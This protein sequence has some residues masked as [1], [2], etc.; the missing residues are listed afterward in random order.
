M[1][2]RQ[3]ATQAKQVRHLETELREAAAKLVQ[4]HKDLG[5]RIR[6]AREAKGWKQKQL[7]AAVHVETVTISRWENAHTAPDLGTLQIIAGALE[8]PISY[9]LVAQPTVE[10][11][12]D[13]R[14]LQMEGRLGSLEVDLR[15]ALGILRELRARPQGNER[16]SL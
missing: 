7:A 9:F 10:Q 8:R 13:S 1:S 3:T 16:G 11:I 5:L 2:Y 4:R 12:P 15:E 6:A 14:L